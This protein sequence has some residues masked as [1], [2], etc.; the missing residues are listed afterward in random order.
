MTGGRLSSFGVTLCTFVL[1]VSIFLPGLAAAAPI[2]RPAILII[3]NAGLGV[4]CV[5]N[6]ANG[7]VGGCGT[8]ANPYVIEGWSIDGALSPECSTFEDVCGGITIIQTTAYVVIRNNVVSHHKL[9]EIYV[10]DSANVRIESN[11]IGPAGSYLVGVQSGDGIFVHDS[12]GVSVSGNTVEC[13]AGS[14]GSIGILISGTSSGS[15][16]GSNSVSGCYSGVSVAACGGTNVSANSVTTSSHSGIV[17]ACSNVV[18]DGNTVTAAAARGI[19]FLGSYTNV[20]ISHN[21][22]TNNTGVGIYT[23]SSGAHVDD[24]IVSYNSGGGIDI[25]GGTSTYSYSG[26][27]IFGNSNYGLRTCSSNV[28]NWTNN[29]WGDSSGPSG[30]GSGSGDAV[31]KCLA[32]AQAPS[33]SPWLTSASPTAGP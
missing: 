13:A 33:F 29:W 31:T 24:N 23:G 19:V 3:G 17:L 16:V 2:S 7:V 9:A 18:A 27:N 30:L 6:A 1:L 10:E 32:G 15:M 8:A 20:T 21:L 12:A 14:V 5:P 28:L 4:S 11:T 25:G 26:N 22:V